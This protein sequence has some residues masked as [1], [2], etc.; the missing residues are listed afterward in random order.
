MS[1]SKSITLF[2]FLLFLI[3]VYSP[4]K[5]FYAEGS[6][7]KILARTCTYDQGAIVR[8]PASHKEI[9]L[10]FTGGDFS[11]GGDVIRNVLKRKDV[12]ASFFFT[13]GFY[14]DASHSRLIRRLLTDGHYLGPHSD[15]HL[16]YCSWEDRD[17]LLVNKQEFISD[18]LDNYKEMENFGIMKEKAPYFIPPYE[19]FNRQIA[20]W[21]EGIGLVLINYTPGTSSN[22]DYTTPS[23]SSYR[24][25]DSIYDSIVHFEK[26]EPSGLNGFLLL[27]HIGTNPDRKDKF[28]DRLAELIDYLHSQE[29]RFSRIDELLA[30][31]VNQK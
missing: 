26:S 31:C 12:K 6:G 21:S 3:C 13:G 9:A 5:D 30:D 18:I 24:S 4:A 15:K 29:Y 2:L 1:D 17:T 14:R 23:M 16:L 8:G 11:D 20:D 19:W 25:S 28:Y 22:A 27:L 7:T 10:I